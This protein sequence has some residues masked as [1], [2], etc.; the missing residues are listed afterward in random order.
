[1][2]KAR[3]FL[4][5]CSPDIELQARDRR[6]ERSFQPTVI[7]GGRRTTITERSDPWE[8]LFGVFDQALLLAEANCAAVLAAS[9]TMLELHDRTDT[10]Q[11]S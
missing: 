6:R 10:G 8:A 2:S 9:L 5:R 3:L 7:E 11:T 4:I 1:M